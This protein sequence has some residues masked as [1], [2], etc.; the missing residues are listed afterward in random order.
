MTVN[1]VVNVADSA[2]ETVIV[3]MYVPVSATEVETTLIL[4]ELRIV[5]IPFGIETA[6]PPLK[7]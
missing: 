2:S 3:M 6:A 1:E 7:E 5:K 4:N